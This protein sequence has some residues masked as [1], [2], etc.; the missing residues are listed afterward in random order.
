MVMVMM[1]LVV[2]VVVAFARV[3]ALIADEVLLLGWLGGTVAPM[4]RYLLGGGGRLQL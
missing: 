4:E 3:T 1:L 2:Q